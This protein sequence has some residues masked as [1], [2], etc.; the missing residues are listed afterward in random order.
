MDTVSRSMS[1]CASPPFYLTVPILVLFMFRVIKFSHLARSYIFHNE[2][3][4]KR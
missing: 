2:V 4:Q 3:L 1:D